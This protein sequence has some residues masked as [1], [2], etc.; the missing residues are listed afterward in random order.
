MLIRIRTGGNDMKQLKVGDKYLTIQLAGHNFVAA[1]KNHD[2]KGN[3]PD[4]K[5]DGVAVWINTKKE[6][7]TTTAGVKVTE[8]D[9]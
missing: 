9:I 4:Y 8:S 2:K 1:F 6:P 5:G 3:E 7:K